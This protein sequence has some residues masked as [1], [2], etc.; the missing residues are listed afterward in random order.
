MRK[1]KYRPATPQGGER[2]GAGRFESGN[3]MQSDTITKYSGISNYR[4]AIEVFHDLHALAQDKPVPLVCFS[5][6]RPVSALKNRIVDVLVAGFFDG[7]RGAKFW[8]AVAVRQLWGKGFDS[9]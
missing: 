1:K 4:L 9:A 2:G 8:V 6:P 5:D 7:E 3:K